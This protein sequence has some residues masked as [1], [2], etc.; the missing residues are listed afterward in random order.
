MSQFEAF[1]IVHRRG[2][3]QMIASLSDAKAAASRLQAKDASVE[4]CEIVSLLDQA[5]LGHVS[6]R[7]A[8]NAFTKLARAKGIL[9]PIEKSVAWED[10]ARQAGLEPQT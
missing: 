1:H 3:T 7:T 8:F 4:W 6:P 2:R 5:A 10:F 9:S